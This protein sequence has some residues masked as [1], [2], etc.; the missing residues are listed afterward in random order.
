MLAFV[1]GATGNVGN[2]TARLLV[3]RGWLVGA[4]VRDIS[5]ARSMLPEAVS[6][7]EGDI[8]DAQAVKRGFQTFLEANNGEQKVVVFHCAGL[9]EQFFRDETI[10]T[11]VNVEG[12]RHVLD[13]ALEY[14][15]HR[16][17]YTSTMDVF[18]KDEDGIL[19]EANVDQNPK[20][21]A[22]ERSKQQAEHVCDEFTRRGLPIIFMNCTAVYGPSPILTG[23]NQLFTQV[24]HGELPALMPGG[25]PVVYIDGV[26]KAHV[27]A[28]ERGRPGERYLL[29]DGHLSLDEFARAVSRAY[30]K[31]FLSFRESYPSGHTPVVKIPR[32]LPVW[33]VK[34]LGSTTTFATRYLHMGQ[35]PL[36]F[37]AAVDLML[38]NP[39]ANTSKAERELGFEP[40]DI[41]EGL[42]NTIRSISDNGFLRPVPQADADVLSCGICEAPFSLTNRRHHC[43]SC[44]QIVC[45]SC[46]IQRIALPKLGYGKPVR[47]CATCGNKKSSI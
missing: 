23:I 28:V 1:T 8:S 39:R 46:S 3:E 17:I 20:H 11:R 15:A 45:G 19:L 25:I 40:Y 13:A 12:T 35:Q 33:L 32:V 14:K 31:I 30:Q 24:L 47:A 26:A 38:W 16:V 22:Y 27:D 42:H 43:R 18:A 10:F 9:P 6:L 4:L 34:L 44:G 36:V 37:R 41:E 21:S 5:R 29:A 7:L 2:A